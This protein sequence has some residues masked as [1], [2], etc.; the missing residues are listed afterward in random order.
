M[1]SY[2]GDVIEISRPGADLGD[3]SNTAKL[4]LD[5]SFFHKAHQSWLKPESMPVL[6][7]QIWISINDVIEVNLVEQ[8]TPVLYG[9]PGLVKNGEHLHLNLDI[10]GSAFF[11]LTCYEELIT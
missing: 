9:Q 7:L 2:D 8:S 4:T 11:M 10:F 3:S 1:E 5:A 6:P